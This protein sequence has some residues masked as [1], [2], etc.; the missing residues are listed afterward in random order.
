MRI[1]TLMQ[2]A[3]TRTEI[4]FDTIQQEMRL[5][6]D[7]VEAFVID[8]AF[9]VASLCPDR[10]WKTRKFEQTFPFQSGKIDI[11]VNFWKSQGKEKIHLGKFREKIWKIVWKSH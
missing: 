1:L 2:M 11:L 7:D 5:G 10:V 8:G 6:A 3:E 9:V 4:D